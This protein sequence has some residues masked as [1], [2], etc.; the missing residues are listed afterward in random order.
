M[1]VPYALLGLLE[2][3]TR[4]GYDLK[5]AYDRHFGG[6]R[7]L[8]VGHVY[9]I[10]AQ[11]VRDGHIVEAGTQPGAG[12]DRKQYAI[13]EAGVTDLA[14]WLAEPEEPQPQLHAVLFVKVELALMSGRPAGEY[15]DA[16]RDRH[17]ARM[18]ELTTARRGA[19]PHGALLADYQ[20]FHLEA[21]LR[22]IEHAAGRLDTLRAAS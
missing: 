7:P 20:L 13:T 5:Q 11:L 16:Q 4:H 2:D 19:G 15:L 3:S 18:R 1:T 14:R 8:R 10:L 9:R 22:W 6:T 21:D 12:P 17:L